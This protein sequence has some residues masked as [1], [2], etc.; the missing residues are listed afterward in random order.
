MKTALHV[1][2]GDMAGGSLAKS[3][4]PGEVFVWHDILYDGPRKP[5][6]PDDDTLHARA[7]FLGES[8]GE[9]LSREYVLETLKAQYAKLKTAERYDRVILWFDA[10]LF[11]QSMLCHI[12]MCMR[13]L[14]METADL[15]CIDAFPG[16]V[17]Y[18]G[19]GQLSP[20]QLASMYDRRQPLTAAQSLFAER[21]DRA[22]AL[23][24]QGAFKELSGCT[25]A[26]L[27]W[28]PAA[29]RRWIEEQPDETTGLSRLEQLAL[30]A[31]GSGCETTTDIFS[32]VSA[33][34]TPP[35]F[36]GDT[37]LWAKIN[38]LA[39]RE[40]PLVRINGPGAR[41]P[42]WEGMADLKLFRLYPT[43]AKAPVL[44]P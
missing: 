22:F 26:P 27:P 4:I 2:S 17:P 40:P 6:W 25:D 31:I 28:V 12:V 42:Q 8:T 7:R 37:T 32:F 39:D 14:K 5:G 20:E 33:R 1:T 9:G 29:V 35:Q 21:V 18:H 23:Q 13:F 16:I 3:G 11:D 24:D 30:A 19:L 43:E 36:W 38:A 10:C 44:A 34:E 41:L 15:L